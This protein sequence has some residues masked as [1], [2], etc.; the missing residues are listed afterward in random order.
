MVKKIP[1]HHKKLLYSDLIDK[2]E[3]EKH[4]RKLNAIQNKL[5]LIVENFKRKIAK[6]RNENDKILKEYNTILYLLKVKN[7]ELGSA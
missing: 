7:K 3:S 5:N 6:K 1:K 2:K 4:I